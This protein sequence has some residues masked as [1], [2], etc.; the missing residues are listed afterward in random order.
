MFQSTALDTYT[1]AR[2]LRSTA[3]EAGSGKSM[4]LMQTM[5]CAQATGWVVLYLPSGGLFPSSFSG[6][7]SLTV[8]ATSPA[9]PLVNS[10]TPH[11]YSST[12]ALFDQP[13]LSARLLSRFVA[14][15][16]GALKKIKTS[17]AWSFGDKEVKQGTGLDE[18]AT[19]NV[20]D[21]TATS[22]LGALFEELS[23]QQS[24][25]SVP[26]AHVT[27]GHPL[28][29]DSATVYPFCSRSTTRK[30]CSRRRLT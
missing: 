3:G 13:A 2:M 7:R 21:K 16:K 26:P 25:V 30:R 20:E 1:H 10:S 15:N 14:A 5:A 9:T 6:A 19:K 24:Y 8:C 12:Q 17:R 22:I 11:V 29:R 27:F 4:L 18:L 23:K 28:T